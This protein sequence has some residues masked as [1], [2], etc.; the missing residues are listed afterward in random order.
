MEDFFCCQLRNKPMVTARTPGRPSGSSTSGNSST[1]PA[2]AISR[3][4]LTH[5]D[6]AAKII[7]RLVE[8]V[9]A[10][11]IKDIEV[12]RV[13]E[14]PGFVRHVGGDAEHFPGAHDDLLSIDGKFQCAIE[15][16]RYLFIVMLVLGD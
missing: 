6:A 11:R 3:N 2:K 5:W 14:R 16:V 9:F 10:R 8:P 4:G 7:V 13:F 12:E 1:A 15:D